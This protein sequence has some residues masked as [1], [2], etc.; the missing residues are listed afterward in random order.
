MGYYDSLPSQQFVVGPDASGDSYSVFGRNNGSTYYTIIGL[1][2]STPDNVIS[3]YVLRSTGDYAINGVSVTASVQIGATSDNGILSGGI[4]FP[5][6]G[7]IAFSVSSIWYRNYP[8]VCP[9]PTVT[10]TPTQTPIQSGDTTPTPTPTPTQTPIQSGD[11]TPTP[12]PTLT[13]TPSSVVTTIFLSVC[14]D[15]VIPQDDFIVDFNFYTQSS[16]DSCGADQTL[17]LDYLEI[18][19]EVYPNSPNE[20]VPGFFTM[21]GTSC[22][23][24]AGEILGDTITGLTITS[25]STPNS[26][27][28]NY[29]VG[30]ICSSGSCVPCSV[31]PT[32]TPTQTPTQTLVL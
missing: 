5:P 27:N 15:S 24:V 22:Q 14:Y 23:L 18:A 1:S 17:P 19:F 30:T 16:G 20:P 9:T 13:P 3:W 4:Y 2:Q 12:T 29:V 32:P 6:T 21:T 26:N 7:R 8:S 10:P 28:A 11:T 25:I 31:T